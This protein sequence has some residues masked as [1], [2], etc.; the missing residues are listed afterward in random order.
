MVID[1]YDV[2]VFVPSYTTD[3]ESLNG[4]LSVAG[5]DLAEV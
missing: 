5:G 1:P 4:S 2:G 3:I